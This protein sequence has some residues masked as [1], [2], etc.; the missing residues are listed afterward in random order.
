MLKVSDLLI[1]AFFDD[2]HD[3]L[4]KK[5]ALMVWLNC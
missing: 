5:I 4:L 3:S 1:Y 2:A